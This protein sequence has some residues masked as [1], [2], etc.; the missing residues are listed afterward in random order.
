[1]FPAP[2]FIIYV[3]YQ[4]YVFRYMSGT[5]YIP[6]IS[7]KYLSGSFGSMQGICLTYA[8]ACKLACSSEA[9]IGFNVKCQMWHW[10]T[11]ATT[12]EWQQMLQ[13]YG[14]NCH[15]FD[16]IAEATASKY[17]DE[18]QSAI[19]KQIGNSA[20]GRYPWLSRRAAPALS[21]GHNDRSTIPLGLRVQQGRLSSSARHDS[22][23]ES[24][25]PRALP[26]TQAICVCRSTLL[27]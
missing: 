10:Q 3:I 22:D 6:G 18:V 13:S 14:S 9:S 8:S 25:D 2:L 16:V 20:A 5:M 23:S 27:L 4:T 12:P 1:M 24:G 11:R 26:A 21:P 7:K 15:C 17:R 19:N